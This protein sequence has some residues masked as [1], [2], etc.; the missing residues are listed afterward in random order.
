M[1]TSVTI[2]SNALQLIGDEPIVSF[3]SPGNGAETAKNLYI[4]TYRMVLAEHFWTFALKDQSLSR[5]SQEPDDET[6][7]QFAFRLPADIIRLYQL[8]PNHHYVMTGDVILSNQDEV[9]ARYVHPVDESLLPAH[10]VKAL[11]YKL[12]A[13]FA[14]AI[15]EDEKKADIY[16]RKYVRMLSQARTIDSQSHPQERIDNMPFINSRFRG[17]G[18]DTLGGR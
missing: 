3:E 17:F 10:F 18:A 5:L 7:F 8:L 4:D 16:E 12:A 11:E 2:A 6:G 14:I 1:T 13:D 9:I 15:T